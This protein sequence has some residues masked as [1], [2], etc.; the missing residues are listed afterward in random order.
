MRPQTGFAGGVF[1]R[2]CCGHLMRLKLTQLLALSLTKLCSAGTHLIA[3]LAINFV[4]VH[5]VH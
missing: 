1:C 5:H 3:C 4:G 2:I